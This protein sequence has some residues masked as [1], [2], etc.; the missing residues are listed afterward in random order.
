[1][2]AGRE[3]YLKAKAPSLRERFSWQPVRPDAFQTEWTN[4]PEAP[5]SVK[6][7]HQ[8][9]PRPL[10]I[11]QGEADT[12][13]PVAQAKALN[14]HVENPKELVL[15]PQANHSFTWQR[16]LLRKRLFEWLEGPG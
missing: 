6:Q 7:V 10:L 1:M 9:A 13:V 8:N 12:N 15:I 14:E 5:I 16:A 2:K 11:L 4:L 3:S